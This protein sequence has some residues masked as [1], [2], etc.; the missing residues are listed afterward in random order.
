MNKILLLE[1]LPEIR[2]WLKALALQVFPNA[3]VSEAARVHDAL[4]LVSASYAESDM[5]THRGEHPRMGAVDVVPCV[6]LSGSTM[7]ACVAICRACSE[8]CRRMA[9]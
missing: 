9:A 6:P 4:A 1:D 3:Q 7:E 8:S 5:R 2:S